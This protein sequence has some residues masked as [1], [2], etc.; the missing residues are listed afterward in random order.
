[1]S[2]LDFYLPQLANIGEQP[3]PLRTLN[4]FLSASPNATIG[5]QEAWW[6]YR[7]EPDRVVGSFRSG[8]EQSLDV[9]TYSDDYDAG[10]T[11]V[12][13]QWLKSNAEEVMNRTL[14]VTSSTGQ[15]QLK[16]MFVYKITKQRPLPTYSVPGL[17]DI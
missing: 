14:A 11:H 10:F 6:E 9:W 13:G 5:Y 15:P 3:I 4:P 1:M 12:N 8:I 2:T 7:N 17:D 16:G